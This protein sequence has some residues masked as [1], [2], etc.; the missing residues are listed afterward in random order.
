[1]PC[2]EQPSVT[3]G[4]ININWPF[5][6]GCSFGGKSSPGICSE[7]ENQ[8]KLKGKPS[9]LDPGKTYIFMEAVEVELFLKVEVGFFQ[10]KRSYIEMRGGL[11]SVKKCIEYVHTL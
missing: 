7:H 4:G 8:K 2:F 1:M 11:S 9:D 5:L 6:L 3:S 10:R